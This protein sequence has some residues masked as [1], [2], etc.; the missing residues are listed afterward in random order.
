MTILATGL[1]SLSLISAVPLPPQ[2][3][4]PT[5]LTIDELKAAASG[6]CP[7]QT[8]GEVITC[9]DALPYINT[10]INK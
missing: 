6:L 7:T 8:S 2:S 4:Q 10:A 1:V 3:L 5:L 9:E